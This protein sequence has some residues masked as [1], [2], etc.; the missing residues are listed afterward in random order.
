V[1][2]LRWYRVTHTAGEVAEYHLSEI[3]VIEHT[4]K[5]SAN[6]KVL[7][8]YAPGAWRHIVLVNKEKTLL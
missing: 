3:E 1:V 6:G 5:V 7:A 8:L 4:L 2:A